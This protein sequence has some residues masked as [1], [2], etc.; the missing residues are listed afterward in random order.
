[1]KENINFYILLKAKSFSFIKSQMF[2]K[3][4]ILS[5]FCKGGN[6]MKKQSKLNIEKLVKIA[7]LGT[8]SSIV[9]LFEFP[10]PIAPPFYE[11]DFSE[12]VVMLGGFAI[13]PSAV[14][15]IEAVK[16][17]LNLLINGTTTVGVGELANFLLGVSLTFLPSF[18]Y[19]YSK[20]KNTK[21]GAVLGMLGGILLFAVLGVVLNIYVLI[22][23][24][25][26]AYGLP[27]EKIV[28]MGSAIFPAVN[29]VE[30]LAVFCVLPFNL[31]KGFLSC[32]IVFLAYK[33]LSG[34]LAKSFVK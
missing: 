22:P 19:R 4:A 21:K 14:F 1:M 17:G 23:F 25:S 6:K 24:Y 3:S 16:I 31:I 29:S 27:I 33:K 28:E 26:S 8:L 5:L 11:M 12:V 7:I 10:L 9:M 18:V 13:G 15:G 34:F 30:K 2:Y 20:F 32:L